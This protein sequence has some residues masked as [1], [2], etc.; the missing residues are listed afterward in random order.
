M[1]GFKPSKLRANKIPKKFGA[2]SLPA[3][4]DWRDTAVTPVKNQGQC[5][6]C[7]SFSTTGSIEGINAIK[8]GKL[9]SLSEQQLVDCSSSFGNEGCNGGM[10]D[11]AFQYTESSKLETEDEYPYTAQDGTCNFDA[12]EGAVGAVSYEDVTSNSPTELAA[13]VAQQPVSVAIE[14]DQSVFQS[15]TGGIMDSA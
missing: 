10:F 11:A 3:S 1:L 14:A 13:A 7:W 2:V 6:S 12:S 15:Y 9:V 4:V 8:T 5:G